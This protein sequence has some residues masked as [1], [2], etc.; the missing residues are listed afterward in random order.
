M[1]SANTRRMM[2]SVNFAHPICE[3]DNARFYCWR[4]F[5]LN[6]RTQS[7]AIFTNCDEANAFGHRSTSVAFSSVA[8]WRCHMGGNDLNNI[9]KP[10]RIR[11]K[12]FFNGYTTGRCDI[13]RI[14]THCSPVRC[15]GYLKPYCVWHI[16]YSFVFDQ[17]L[18]ALPLRN[19]SHR[20]NDIRSRRGTECSIA[21]TQ[22]WQ[23]FKW[24]FI[25]FF[26]WVFL[27][28]SSSEKRRLN[29]HFMQIDDLTECHDFVSA[30]KW[31]A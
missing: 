14:Q 31:D 23:I 3:H 19:Y 17:K 13:Q 12:A 28:R 8:H 26:S 10:L 25:V 4:G 2:Q 9:V 7:A 18:N 21:F 6:Q 27:Q 16:N 29:W 30:L 20:V 15:N 11:N 24:F 5:V 1:Q 22:K